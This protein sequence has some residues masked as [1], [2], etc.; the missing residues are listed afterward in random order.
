MELATLGLRVIGVDASSRMLD[1]ARAKL[2]SAGLLGEHSV[3]LRQGDA[4][5]LPLEDCEVDAA[6]AHMMLQYLDRPG[7]AV[8]EMQRVVRPGGRIV[9][10]DFVRHDLE[11]MRR[12]LGVVSLGFE[13]DEIS[14]WFE[15]AG[16]LEL[17]VQVEESAPR[18]RDLPS[19]FIASARV[20]EA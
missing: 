6:F 4:S 17:R 20:A 18:D 12:E 19:T 1:A 5:A 2:E 9:I 7:D 14:H 10:V 8:Q 16:L 11:W 13:P 15:R 3:E